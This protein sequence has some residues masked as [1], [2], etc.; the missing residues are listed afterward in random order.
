MTAKWALGQ[1]PGPVDLSAED[2]SECPAVQM[3]STTCG[4][5]ALTMIA[6]TDAHA[7]T[8]ETLRE[9]AQNDPQGAAQS[10]PHADLNAMETLFAAAQQAM[11]SRTSHRAMMG[12][13]RWPRRWGTPPWGAARVAHFLGHDYQDRMVVATSLP[14]YQRVMG[15]SVECV[16]RG[17]PVMLYAGADTRRGVTASVPRHVVVLHQ[18]PSLRGT[19][20]LLV[21]DP[22]TAINTQVSVSDV[23]N[24][25]IPSN[26]LGGWQHIMWAVFP[27]PSSDRTS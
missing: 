3:D 19:D 25:Q 7:D 27:R 10:A 6:L 9:L 15:H 17:F 8:R 21:F 1:H 2:G 13:L 26:A 18:P 14:Q 5:A 22:A 16:R 24:R 11:K 23:M 12:L 4:S 20:H